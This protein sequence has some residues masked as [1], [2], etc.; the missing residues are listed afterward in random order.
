MCRNLDFRIGGRSVALAPIKL[1]RKKLY[2]WTEMRT[3]TSDGTLCRQAGLDKSG[4]I[5]IPKGATKIG[6]IGE[7]GSWLEKNELIAVH[8]DGSEAT[9][10]ASSFDNPIELSQKAS[11][12]ELLN[13]RVAAV[14]QLTGEQ[15]NELCNLIGSDIY[16]FDFSYKG[17]YESAKAFILVSG[18][19]PYIITGEEMQFDFIALE[20]QGVLTEMEEI[21]I[22]EDELDFS[23]M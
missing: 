5:I 21:D 22:E 20:E 13:L 3:T 11:A 17:G 16:Y 4:Q 10:V 2:G 19:T 23:M 15:G 14:Y 6:I 9:T 12:E 18:D 8:A 1:E 7:D